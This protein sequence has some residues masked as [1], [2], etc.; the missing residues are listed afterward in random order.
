MRIYFI[1]YAIKIQCFGQASIGS[2]SPTIRGKCI[3]ICIFFSFR[4]NRIVLKREGVTFFEFLYKPF[5]F[6]IRPVFVYRPDL[7]IQSENGTTLGTLCWRKKCRPLVFRDVDGKGNL[8]EVRLLGLLAFGLW[9]QPVGSSG[10]WSFLVSNIGPLCFLDLNI[11][12]WCL[13]LP[14]SCPISVGGHTRTH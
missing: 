11:N 13:L 12:W 8:I 5:Y 3:I 6:P 9:N 1:Y 2:T 10:S 4:N 7:S 14:S